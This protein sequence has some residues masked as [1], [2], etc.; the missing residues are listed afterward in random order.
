MSEILLR[1]ILIL[2]DRRER[3]RIRQAIERRMAVTVMP[4]AS[5]QRP[6]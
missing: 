1:Q 6:Q 4:V 5:D 2:I 3:E